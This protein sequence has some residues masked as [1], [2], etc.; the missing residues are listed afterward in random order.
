MSTLIQIKHRHTNTVLFEYEA[1]D[2]EVSSGLAVRAALE[3]ATKSGADL[4]GADLGGADLVGARPILQIG[5]IGSRSDYLVAFVTDSGLRIRA[6]CFFGTRDEF[7]A[8]VESKHG[9]SVHAREYTS[10]LAMIDAHEAL[11]IPAEQPV[12]EAAQ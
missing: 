9:N 10:A 8:R 12:A 1:S 2:A 7:A 11:W 3:K 6:G 5:P 4:G